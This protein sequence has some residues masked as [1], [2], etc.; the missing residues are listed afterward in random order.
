MKIHAL[1]TGTVRIKRT[2][3]YGRGPGPLRQVN[4][5]LGREFTESLPIHVWVIE[6]P[7]GVIVVDTGELAGAPA[8]PTRS[9][10]LVTTPVRSVC[11]RSC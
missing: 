6:H 4:T 3:R 1:S 9:R 5:F 8:R 7:Q 2:M 10:P 11:W